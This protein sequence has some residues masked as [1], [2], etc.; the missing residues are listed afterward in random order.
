MKYYIT[1][2]ILQEWHG[3]IEADSLEEAIEKA[4]SNEIENAYKGDEWFTPDWELYDNPD[5]DPIAECDKDGNVK[6]YD[7]D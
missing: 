1:Y 7:G 2:G 3:E 4:K 5:D 6:Q